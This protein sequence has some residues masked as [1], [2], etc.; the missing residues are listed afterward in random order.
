MP[1]KY[2]KIVLL[3]EEELH[4]IAESPENWMS[5]L[6]TAAKNYKYKFRDQVLIY[7]QKPDAT[8]CADIETWNR[9]GRWVNKGTKGISLLA[10]ST[11][12]YRLRH[13]FDLSDT[14]S[15]AGV[16]VAVWRMQPRYEDAVKESLENSFGEAG[17][18][19]GFE[20]MLF[21]IANNAVDDNFT[22]YYSQLKEMIG[23]RAAGSIDADE[24]YLSELVKNSVGYMLLVRMGYDAEAYYD[25][26][27]F[28]RIAFLFV[29][30][31]E[32]LAAF[33]GATHAVRAVRPELL[34]A[35]Y[36]DLLEKL[37]TFLFSWITSFRSLLVGF[38]TAAFGAVFLKWSRRPVFGTTVFTNTLCQQMP[39]VFLHDLFFLRLTFRFLLLGKELMVVNEL[40]LVKML[41]LAFWGAHDL[42]TVD[43]PERFAADN[44][45]FLT[46]AMIAFLGIPF[47]LDAL[48]FCGVQ[49][50]PRAVLLLITVWPVLIAAVHADSLCELV[51]VVCVVTFLF[52]PRPVFLLR[53]FLS[54]NFRFL[55]LFFLPFG[56]PD[57]FLGESKIEFA[58][59][60]EI[61]LKLLRPVLALAAIWL[62]NND[63]VN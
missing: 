38:V 9:L 61:N 27:D 62:M 4:K 59:E 42:L 5:F 8:A 3:A 32:L 14:N 50:L 23:G 55:N 31:V 22:D 12:P 2:Q 17:V 28:A 24:V 21:S 37:V 44:A 11:S 54:D 30:L 43:R 25:A 18:E 40:F 60:I 15:R 35:D 47:C 19:Y 34:A 48:G 33:R 6:D 56:S 46:E 13:V 41:V 45:V 16:K 1:S 26:D 36:A 57:F 39:A 7:A 58:D 49:A 10:D 51:T 53:F 20:D 63:L 29:H 52:L